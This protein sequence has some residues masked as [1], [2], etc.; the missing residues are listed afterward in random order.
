MFEIFFHHH[1]QVYIFFLFHMLVHCC[2]AIKDAVEVKI[3]LRPRFQL[4]LVLLLLLDGRLVLMKRCFDVV[5]FLFL[6]CML[7]KVFLV[8]LYCC[9][10]FFGF[11]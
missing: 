5:R 1:R 8:V 6:V 4:E 9:I 10:M 2:I 3:W 7:D 11:S